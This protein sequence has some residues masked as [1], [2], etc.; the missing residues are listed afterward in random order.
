MAQ[1]TLDELSTRVAELE[2][3]LA[4]STTKLEDLT[5][6]IQQNAPAAVGNVQAIKSNTGVEG[7]L[8]VEN[9]SGALSNIGGLTYN[10]GV[11][12]L[13]VPTNIT[14]GGLVTANAFNASAVVAPLINGI[15]LNNLGDNAHFLDETGNYTR[16]VK[17]EWTRA[18][19]ADDLSPQ[20]PTGIGAINSLIILFGGASPASPIMEVDA[21]GLFTVRQSGYFRVTLTLNIAGAPAGVPPVLIFR[22]NYQ[23][24]GGALT[25]SYFA[26]H[27]IASAA[28]LHSF[29]YVF[30]G[31]YLIN[32]TFTFEMVRD[33]IGS[34]T[35]ELIAFA[36]TAAGWG[37]VPS[38]SAQVDFFINA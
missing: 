31:N 17:G 16:P 19:S 7:A 32:D 20:I 28:T 33:P 29:T 26:S 4:Q 6:G 12:T 1:L 13:E 36:S 38:A 11:V 34:N 23:V 25:Q 8:L 21:A 5:G 10:A 24:F 30:S 2:Q 15:A 22:Q 3:V 37:I 14:A 18:L 35:G 9:A 27:D